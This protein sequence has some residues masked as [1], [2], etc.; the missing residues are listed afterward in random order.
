M[1]CGARFN[2]Q[3]DCAVGG[4]FITHFKLFIFKAYSELS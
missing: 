2:F 1:M 3:R 4:Y